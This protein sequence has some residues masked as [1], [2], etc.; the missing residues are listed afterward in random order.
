VAGNG[1]AFS[2]YQSST[3]SVN[4]ATATK[5]TFDTETFDTNN[6]F[7]SSRFT[8]TVAGYYQLNWR[9]G[10]NTGG[11]VENYT[12]L[13]K[14]GVGDVYGL[15]MLSQFFGSGGSTLMYFNGS[16]YVEV[17][18]YQNSGSSKNTTASSSETWFNGCLV[19]SA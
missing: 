19:R 17:Y 3:T 11:G 15:D 1:P 4:T 6:N 18:F 10:C 2:A 13:F 7:A 14:N 9:V 5:I 12:R 16:D 8:P